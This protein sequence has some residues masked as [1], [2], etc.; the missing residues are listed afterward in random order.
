M[1]ENQFDPFAAVRKAQQTQAGDEAAP[2]W[3]QQ[4]GQKLAALEA[5]KV[6]QERGA[7]SAILGA[8]DK[9][10]AA[11]DGPEWSGGPANIGANRALAQKMAAGLGWTGQQWTDFDRLV[12]KE[13]G[14]NNEAQN[15][16]SSAYGIGQFLDST[17]GGYG[18]KTADPRIQLQ[19]M[20]KYVADRYK[21]PSAAL[22]FHLKN[23][24]Y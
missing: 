18:A 22:A 17:W 12:M 15:P 4:Y 23:N 20:L 14:Y 13:S 11:Y 3:Q 5:K 1:A 24:W 9:V 6:A 19:Y 10:A 21:D 7:F 8:T 16:T 2:E